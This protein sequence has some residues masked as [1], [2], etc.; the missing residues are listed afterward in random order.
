MSI[1]KDVL[2]QTNSFTQHSG[3]VKGKVYLIELKSSYDNNC[4]TIV[5]N[6]NQTFPKVSVKIS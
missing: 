6:I 1:R 2:I 5:F 4:L 3:H